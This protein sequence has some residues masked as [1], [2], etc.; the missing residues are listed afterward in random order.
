MLLLMMW[1]CH[2]GNAIPFD[3]YTVDRSLILNFLVSHALLIE[4][5]LCG[6]WQE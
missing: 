2:V 6:Y 1:M 3:F 5:D 4:T